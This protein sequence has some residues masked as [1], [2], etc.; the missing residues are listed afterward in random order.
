MIKEKKNMMIK[1]NPE[2]LIKQRSRVEFQTALQSEAAFRYR[3][4]QEQSIAPLCCFS[5]T[6]LKRG[7]K[8]INF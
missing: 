8:S 6:R 4:A 1:S 2:T 5:I 7:R 3:F